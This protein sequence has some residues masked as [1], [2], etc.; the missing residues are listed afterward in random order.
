M[1]KTIKTLTLLALVI[2]MSSFAKMDTDKFIGTY[3]GSASD[4][5]QIKLTINA[6]H[7]FYYQDFSVSN[8]KLIVKG[9]W[10]QKGNKIVLVDKDTK[11]HN[12]WTFDN[13]GKVAKSHKGLTFYRLCKVD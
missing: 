10:T 12:V 11:F 3:S 4:P 7:T 2:L 8:K 13:D 9:N 1:T 5:A 6:D